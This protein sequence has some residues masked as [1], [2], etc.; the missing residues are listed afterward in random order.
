M[1]RAREPLS[2]GC[3][4]QGALAA[5]AALSSPDGVRASLLLGRCLAK[6]G[7]FKEA[8]AHLDRARAHPTLAPYARLWAAEAALRLGDPEGARR[9]LVEAMR[10]GLAG[11]A[12]VRAQLALVRASLE[13][14]RVRE[15]EL[16][17][18]QALGRARRD[19]E[20]AWAWWWLGRAAEAR[21]AAQEARVRYATAWWGFPGSEASKAAWASLRT[22]GALPVPPAQA[23]AERARRLR[24]RNAALR[25]WRAALRQGL[26]RE[27][28][29]EAHLQL[30]LSQLGSPGAVASL[31]RAAPDPRYGPQA[32]YWL[33]VAYA[34]LGQEALAVRTWEQLTRFPNEPWTGRALLA[35]AASAVRRGDLQAADRWLSHA[36]RFRTAAGDRARWERGWLR[37]RQR[38]YGEAEALWREAAHR[39]P[40]SP[41]APAAL[42]WAALARMRRG[43]EARPLLQEV[44]AR[45]PHAYYGQRARQRLGLASAPP[46][47]APASWELPQRRYAS[48]A[49]EL[50]ALG[51][52]EEA[53][54]EIEALTRRTSSRA[55]VR[56]LAAVRLA[57]GKVS[58]SVGAAESLVR[59]WSPHA[60]GL[61]RELWSL[62]YPLAHWEEVERSAREHGLDPFLV[63]AVSREESR[64]DPRAVSA[65][66]AVGLTQLLPST[67]RGLDPSVAPEDLVNPQTNV[68]LGTAYLAAR[69][70]QF[71]DDVV[72]ALVAYNAGPAAAQR[73]LRLRADSTDEFIE[74]IPY[75]E[76][77]AY[78]KRVLESY[79][80]Y[81]W[82]YGKQK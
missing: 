66:G 6:E 4:A 81:R 20:K 36:A 30:G 52:Y 56:L 68:R 57:A 24:D 47:P 80:I 15:A 51:L 65:A 18:R 55:L 38:R 8:L 29:A 11:S 44:A 78:V 70:R 50:A 35:L 43:L 64:F 73:F 69:L 67:A 7:R 54:D 40:E 72:V 1:V 63:L 2:G 9:R 46:R 26:P 42:Y 5:L 59:P 49:V 75:A 23:R 74:R 79:G 19:D 3:A 37:Y 60:A 33:G 77:R 10:D 71:G 76:T 45:Y 12:L 62:A 82:L 13:L 22:L 25:E 34:R 61:D 39:H 14:G 31:T 41:S 27:L 28:A 21:G 32:R 58:G 16:H 53:E 48:R 17:A